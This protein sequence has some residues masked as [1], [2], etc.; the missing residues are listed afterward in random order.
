MVILLLS[1]YGG[2][3][4]AKLNPEEILGSAL[5]IGEGRGASFQPL[6]HQLWLGL[7]I[8]E[9]NGPLQAPALRRP[10]TTC[11]VTE[12]ADHAAPP[13]LATDGLETCQAEQIKSHPGSV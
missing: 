9:V 6:P 3:T 1:V 12:E 7:F 11:I 2:A 5:L 10:R 13:S 4:T 8:H